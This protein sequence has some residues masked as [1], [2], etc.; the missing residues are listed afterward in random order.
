MQAFADQVVV[1]DAGSTDGT[2]ELVKKYQDYKTKVICLSTEDWFAQNGRQKLA[3]FQNKAKEHLDTDYYMVIQSDEILQE[4]SFRTAREAIQSGREAYMCWRI[5][6]WW[7]AYT[8]LNVEQSRKPCS[9]EVIR[10][11]KVGYDSVDDGENIAAPNVCFDYMD[12]LRI[13]HMGFVRKMDVMKEKVIHMQESV[14]E[15]PHDARLDEDVQFNPDRYFDREKDSLP[16]FEPL[17]RHIQKWAEERWGEEPA[18]IV[19]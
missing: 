8:M 4:R 14:F 9:T 15:T 19:E 3:Y 6:L 5:N 17:P 2:A 12:D 16:L 1:L 11:A 7:N 13:Y 10:L 18:K